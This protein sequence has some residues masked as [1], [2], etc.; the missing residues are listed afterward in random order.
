VSKTKHR[1]TILFFGVLMNKK[2]IISRSILSVCAVATL[3]VPL[4]L[5]ADIYDDL[6][7]KYLNYLRGDSTKYST[8]DVDIAPK[9]A[10]ITTKAN[11]NWTSMSTNPSSTGYLWSDLKWPALPS[12]GPLT[13][14]VY[15]RNTTNNYM[16]LA[17][18]ALA[19]R[20]TGS[21]LKGNA[22]LKNNINTALL[23]MH[24]SKKYSPALKKYWS[25]WDWNVTVGSPLEMNNIITLMY[26]DIP[27]ATRDSMYRAMDT[28]CLDIGASSGG[29]TYANLTWKCWSKLVHGINRKSQA[30]IDYAKANIKPSFVYNTSG[31]GDGYYSDGSF[32][33]HGDL[34]YTGGY[35]ANLIKFNTYFMWLLEG[36]TQAVTWTEKKNI[37]DFVYKVYEPCLTDGRM[38]SAVRGREI[39]RAGN[40][41]HN[42]GHNVIGA[43]YRISLYGDAT[44]ALTMKRIVK[45]AVLRDMYKPLMIDYKAY[46]ITE[47]LGIRAIKNDAAVSE[48]TYSS[49]MKVFASMARFVQRSSTYLAAVSSFSNKIQNFEL[50]NNENLNNP[51]QT[52]GYLSIYTRDSSQFDDNYWPTVDRNR[53]TGTTFRYGGKMDAGTGTATWVGGVSLNG[54][55]GTVG[56]DIIGKGGTMANF[57][58]KKAWFFFDDE[59]VCLGAGIKDGT[60]GNVETTVENMKLNDNGTNALLV[61]GTAKST[62]LPWSETMSS[63][64]KIHLA[65][66]NGTSRGYYFPTAT[67]V[68]GKRETRSGKWTDINGIATDATVY[69]KKY[70]TLYLNHG[71]LP[72]NSKYAYVSLP[73]Y[74]SAQVDT[75]AASPEITV[76][77]NDSNAQAVSENTKKMVGM[78][79]WKDV[80]KT[81]GGI[82]VNKKAAVMTRRTSDTIYVSVSDPT[83]LNTGTIVVTLDTL[84]AKAIKLDAGVV[85]T[86]LNPLKITVTVKGSKG[87]TYNAS[88]KRSAAALPPAAPTLSSPS[89]EAT[90]IGKTPVLSWN[91]VAGA[92]SYR[93]LVA[94]TSDL[95]E[96]IIDITTSSTN[97]TVSSEI[98]D[99]DTYYWA[100]SAINADG[101]GD[102]S[103]MFTF[104]TA[105]A[106]PEAPKALIPSNGDGAVST[107]CKIIWNPSNANTYQLQV[108]TVHDF[109]NIIY[110]V[111]GITECVDTMSGLNSRTTYYYRLRGA[112]CL[113]AGDWSDTVRFMTRGDG[114]DENLISVN[115]KVEATSEKAGPPAQPAFLA[116]DNERSWWQWSAA[117]GTYPQNVVVDLGALF[118]LDSTITLWYSAASRSYKYK[119][120]GSIDG[121][122]FTT[123]ADQSGRTATGN[124]KDVNLGANYW[125]YVR[126]QVTGSSA[127]WA[128]LSEFLVYGKPHT[129]NVYS[130]GASADGDEE[131]QTYYATNLVDGDVGTRWSAIDNTFPKYVVID[132]GVDRVLDS[133][134]IDF[135]N[136]A[137]RSYQYTISTWK[138]GEDEERAMLR[139]DRTDNTT[140]GNVNDVIEGSRTGRYIKIQITGC[141]QGGWASI[142]EVK[143]YA[144]N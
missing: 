106:V 34:A 134:Y 48:R 130:R 144:H 137:T 55:Y 81:Y 111:S 94:R 102:Q 14:N 129:V 127:G 67:T 8:S 114:S 100:V 112:N 1:K 115:C 116:V 60:S 41:D 52:C 84:V 73:N 37:Y 139:V 80:S 31:T 89:N 57:R 50:V 22:T 97:Y 91:S 110:D 69:S 35:G 125:R 15:L 90:C 4:Q 17:E 23:W 79:N 59:I 20:T 142:N 72:T 25:K 43:L 6:R 32:L 120:E 12:S 126:L 143:V 26:T 87:K 104:S 133:V 39:S 118:K 121:V 132:L 64:T 49:S 62:S 83:Q 95:E 45:N 38:I 113:G 5:N 122:S 7:N 105:V 54:K 33:Q 27:S 11:A 68:Y 13:S 28:M 141:P 135:Y 47:L 85:V 3:L 44:N 10:D 16:R 136:G 99:F 56:Q 58:A 71:S 42:S 108:S 74:T 30:H 9:I 86:S 18:M 107:D 66:N 77:V 78:C 98:D 131:Y 124:S 75:Y 93:V 82:N 19:Y 70:A 76:L 63:V 140:L 61:N 2:S 36:T 53:L 51:A 103:T 117:D 24:T 138:A 96:P 65:G 29:M 40:D 128:A 119:I 123:L 21:S 46:N 101:E 109:G 88:F 92:T